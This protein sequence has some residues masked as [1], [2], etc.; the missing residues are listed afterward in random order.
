MLRKKIPTML[1]I[2]EGLQ[3]EYFLNRLKNLYYDNNEDRNFSIEID[4]AKGGAPIS[5][6]RKADRYE[7]NFVCK[8]VI[9][10][11]DQGTQAKQSAIQIAKQKKIKYL[12]HTPCLEATLLLVIKNGKFLTDEHKECEEYKKEFRDNIR[13]NLSINTSEKVKTIHY[14][15]YFS[16]DSFQ[17]QIREQEQSIP[18]LKEI[19]PYIKNGCNVT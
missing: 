7:G 2:G 9:F 1:I 19:I 16:K 17:T 18:F 15:R 13:T 12:M 4:N 14:K 3:D 11:D 8:I 5:V 6:V 10:D